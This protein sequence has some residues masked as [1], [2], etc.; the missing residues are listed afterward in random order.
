VIGTAA[1][2]SE[3]KVIARSRNWIEV[4]TDAGKGWIS[5]NLL[6]RHPP[7]RR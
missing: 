5:G 4:E 1:K 6:G 7:S 3:V 2:G